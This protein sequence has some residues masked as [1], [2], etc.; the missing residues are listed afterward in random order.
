MSYIDFLSWSSIYKSTY[1]SRSSPIWTGLGHAGPRSRFWSCLV[2]FLVRSPHGQSILRQRCERNP[3][4]SKLNT[5]THLIDL[6][7]PVHNTY[8]SGELR[9]Y[10]VLCT[11]GIT[12]NSDW[13][14]RKTDRKIFVGR[15]F[16]NLKSQY[17]RRTN[18]VS[19][20]LFIRNPRLTRLPGNQFP[21]NS[22]CMWHGSPS[23]ATGA[24]V[25]YWAY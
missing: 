7:C 23:K 2:V 18:F 1:L 14:Q 13:L 17:L 10:I 22:I 9:R 20:R 16:S 6:E 19:H 25:G 4:S 11:T 24:P 12:L 15:L 3:F 5:M 21:Q 8:W